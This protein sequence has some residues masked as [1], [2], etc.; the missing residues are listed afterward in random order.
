M[1][2]FKYFELERTHEK[3]DVSISKSD[4]LSRCVTFL[5]PNT[6]G[7][8]DT[9]CTL[10]SQ[11]ACVRCLWWRERLEDGYLSLALT[12]ELS[13]GKA[14]GSP[15]LPEVNRSALWIRFYLKSSPHWKSLSVWTPTFEF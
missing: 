9:T 12:V 8:K 6:R 1:E 11:N 13:V 2:H 15:L 7:K 4:I 10:I 14:P 3:T 5:I